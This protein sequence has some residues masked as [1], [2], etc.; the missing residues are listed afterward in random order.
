M[1]SPYTPTQPAGYSQVR[2][3]DYAMTDASVR[4]SSL[5]NLSLSGMATTYAQ[6]QAQPTSEHDASYWRKM[7][8]DLGIDGNVDPTSAYGVYQA[9]GAG[10]SASAAASQASYGMTYRDTHVGDHG[11]QSHHPQP[12]P[13]HYQYPVVNAYQ[14]AAYSSR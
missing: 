5:S 7:W 8:C 13:Q 6:Y 4:H 1:S 2:D 10:D 9:N 11:Y 3:G 12:Q 14:S